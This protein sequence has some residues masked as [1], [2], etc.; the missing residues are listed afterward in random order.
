[1]KSVEKPINPRDGIVYV[2]LTK[3]LT[4]VILSI[5]PL[6]SPRASITFPTLSSGT[7]ICK[8]SNGSHTTP[9][10][11]FRITSGLDTCNSKPSRRIFSIKIDKCNSP[12]PDTVHDS[13]EAFST[14]KLTSL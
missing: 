11:S 7:S 6:L 1:M 12:R 13:L 3:L 5:S 8:S 14:F 10:I 9:S 4:L 2:N